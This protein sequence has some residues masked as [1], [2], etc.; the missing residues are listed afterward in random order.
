MFLQAYYDT[1]NVLPKEEMADLEVRRKK[2]LAMLTSR[3]FDLKEALKV[4]SMTTSDRKQWTFLYDKLVAHFR[5]FRE[6][7]YSAIL[8]KLIISSWSV[9]TDVRRKSEI[10]FLCSESR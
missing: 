3:Q 7:N 9:S 10:A 2:Y 1:F 6:C 4:C 5:E 8:R